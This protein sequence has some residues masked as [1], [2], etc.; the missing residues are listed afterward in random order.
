MTLTLDGNL[1]EISRLAA[2]IATLSLPEEA[3]FQLNL[4]LEELFTNA[5]EHGGCRGM[6]AAVEIGFD[7]GDTALLRVD[8]RDRGAPYNPLSAPLPDFDA[9]LAERVAGGLGVHFV[10]QIMRNLQYDRSGEW[11]RLT[12]ELQ[13]NSL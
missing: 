13:V 4:A 7:T 1:S 11:N 2:A 9:P 10:R 12:M 3:E 5:V 8:Y 6:S